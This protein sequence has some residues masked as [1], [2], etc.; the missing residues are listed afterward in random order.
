GD[1]IPKTPYPPPWFHYAHTSYSNVT[2]ADIIIQHDTT[3]ES[4]NFYLTT[5]EYGQGR[6]VVDVIGHTVVSEEGDFLGIPSLKECQILV[7]ALYWVAEGDNISSIVSY[8]WDFDANVDVDG[9]GYSTND[10]EATG[11]TPTHCYGDDGIYTVTLTVT[12]SNGKS[13]TDTM[14]V[15]VKN[16]APSI[17]PFGPFVVDEDTCFTIDTIAADPGSDDLTFT[18]D[19]G[20]GTSDNVTIHYNNNSIP[21]PYPSPEGNFPF[22]TTD[23]VRHIYYD[24]GTYTIN[25]TVEDDDGGVTYNTTTVTVNDLPPLPPKLYINVSQDGDDV[26]LYWD[27]PPSLGIE[28]YLIYRSTSQ[29]GFDFNSVWVNTSAQEESGEP[30]PIPLRT[31]WNDTSAALPGNLSYKEQLYYIIRA[32]NDDGELSS[33]SRTVGKWTKAFLPGISTFSLPLE[34]IE[35]CKTDY[36]T[37]SMNADYIKYMD[38]ATHTWMRHSFLDGETNN[39]EMKPGEGYEVKF[40]TRTNYTFTGMP[41]AMISY[42]DDS[43]FLGFNPET[44]A[45]NL[46]V[47]IEP[48]GNVN[49]TWEEPSNMCG[50]DWYE[51]YYSNTRDGFFSPPDIDHEPACPPINYGTNTTTIAGLGAKNPGSM[52]YFMVVPFNSLGIRGASTYSIGIWTE[53]YLAEHDT[54]GIPLKMADNYTADWYCTSLPDTVGINYYNI[55]AQ[56]WAWHSARMPEGAYDTVLEM[57]EGYQI[58]TA[59]VSVFTFIGV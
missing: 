30:Y 25:L 14:L 1:L 45:R 32:V 58:S 46:S 29:T 28:Y 18:W 27:P 5:E 8:S 42:D 51:V 17:H 34:P 53:E 40:S 47:A 9:D 6:V 38:P 55:S 16:V 48:N 52:L 36:Y 43:G 41:G 15:T 24:D 10:T 31:I 35:T 4:K 7:N 12:D 23:S 49:L 2:T 50:G 21:D 57:T 19:W 56:R 39:T 3:P 33:T 11:P 44:G 26:I 20:D 59:K 54:F 22:N 13:D 37:T